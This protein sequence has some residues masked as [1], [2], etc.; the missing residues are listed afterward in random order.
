MEQKF[1]ICKSCGAVIM[2]IGDASEICCNDAMEEL[3]AGSVDAAFEKHIPVY[4]VEGNIVSVTV[5]SVLHPMLPEHYIE[6]IFLKTK[7]G[8][9][10]KRLNPGEEPKASFAL[11]DGDE[12]EAVYAYCNLHSLWKTENK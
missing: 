4:T 10:L 1:Y 11:C 12:V 9:Q 2:P 5:G 3:V 7:Q 6:W 8:S